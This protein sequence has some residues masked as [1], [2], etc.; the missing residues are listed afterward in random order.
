MKKI[1]VFI[2]LDQ[3]VNGL[4]YWKIQLQ[5]RVYSINC[6]LDNCNS[7][8]MLKKMGDPFPPLWKILYFLL[9]PSLL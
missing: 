5:I 8:N 4:L 7:N 9:E 2:Q 6:F 3:N 1:V